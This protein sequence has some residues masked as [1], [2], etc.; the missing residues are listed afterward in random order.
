MTFGAQVNEAES[1]RM[2]HYALDAGVNFIDTADSYNKG[3]TET[4]LGKALEGKRGGVVLTSKV[5]GQVGEY[6]MRDRGLA[7]WH[8]LRGVEASLK[9]L[10][11]DCLDILFLHHPDPGTPLEESLTACDILVRQGKVIYYGMS[12]FSAWRITQAKWLAERL[13]LTAPVISQNPYNLLTRSAELEFF[14]CCQELQVGLVVYNPLAGGLLTGKH[15]PAQGPEQNTRFQL[16]QNYYNRY[17]HDINFKAIA[18]LEQIA[19][20]A[21]K[22]MVQL[23][24]QWTLAQDM[25][26]AA[27][28]GATRLAQLEENIA[29]CEGKLDPEA[30]TAC[31]AAWQMV[32]GTTF[33]YSRVGY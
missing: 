7:R 16:N 15:N 2:V 29:A 18:E 4:I 27:I 11:T 10:K 24:L 30:V 14:S 13:G 17:W 21:G 19:R 8:I 25:I 31:D 1:I 12:N 9:R 6:P 26:D 22:S 23:A 33:H 28:V 20:Q 32:K 3:V 5:Y